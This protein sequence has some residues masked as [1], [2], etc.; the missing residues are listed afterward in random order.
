MPAEV[1]GR[2]KVSSPLRG[3]LAPDPDPKPEKESS[4]FVPSQ[5]MN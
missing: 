4:L 1:D 5:R 3:S 2:C